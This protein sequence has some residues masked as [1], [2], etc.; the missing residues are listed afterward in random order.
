M[1]NTE[2]IIQYDKGLER[3]IFKGASYY[4]I[5]ISTKTTNYKRKHD[6]QLLR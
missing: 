1:H 5:I 4:G 3:K 6:L 2:N